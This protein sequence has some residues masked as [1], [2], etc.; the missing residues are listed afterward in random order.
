MRLSLPPK[1][2]LR[3]GLVI[4]FRDI[5][6]HART[7][8]HI[9]NTTRAVH[10]YRKAVRRARALLVMCRPLLSDDAYHE[11]AVALRA[12]HRLHSRLRDVDALLPVVR[13]L[14][15]PKRMAGAK[16][17]VADDL[18]A[19]KKSIDPGLV[20]AML[21]EGATRI[22]P[23]PNRLV[24]EFPNKVRMD[25]MIDGVRDTYRRAR[26]AMRAAMK[27]GRERDLHDWRKRTKELNYQLEL[28]IAERRGKARKLH[29]V[30]DDMAEE[31]GGITDR[32]NLR[33]YAQSRETL[34]GDAAVR[35]LAK[36]VG[37]EAVKRARLAFEDGAEA[38][39]LKPGKFAELL[40]DLLR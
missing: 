37:G 13:R 29:R 24:E 10:E 16:V 8:T 38:F 9:K 11:L 5:V 17:A 28:L 6:E 27:H 40:S 7:A 3:N 26:A 20:E 1:A 36:R 33:D 39:H 2:S 19:Q 35:R 22:A 18:K 34:R 4:A 14:E 12:A 25:A 15:V 30:F 32:L 23:I 21:I 31:L